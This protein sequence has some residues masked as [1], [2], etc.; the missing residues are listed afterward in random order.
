MKITLF[1]PAKVNLFFRVLWKRGDG[2]HEIASLMEAISLGDSLTFEESEKDKLF[3][4]DPSLPADERNL[5]IQGVSLFRK[6]WGGGFPLKV[7]LE[8]KIPIGGGLGGGSG[9]LATTLWALNLLYE[10]GKTEGE[11]SSLSAKLSSDAPFFFSHGSAYVTGRG[12]IVK[13]LSPLFFP[14]LWVAKGEG[15]ISTPLSYK[16]CIPNAISIEDPEALLR[17]FY[18]STPQP[19]NDLEFSSFQIKP[20]LKEQKK[21]LLSL[22]FE[23][24]CLTGSGP[25]FYCLGNIEAPSLEGI[26][27]FKAPSIFREAG[28]WYQP[29]TAS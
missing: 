20:E 26:T 27:F 4:S 7:T 3:V 6:E 23:A 29:S 22:G 10:K 16:L 24:V 14:Q 1:S 19:F 8:K 9:N 17:K 28:S 2:F 5:I 11:L 25:S 21:K 15:S 12:E 18:E 13:N